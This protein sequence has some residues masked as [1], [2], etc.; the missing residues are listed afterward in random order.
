MRRKCYAFCM[1]VIICL[2]MAGQ[3]ALASGTPQVSASASGASASKGETV[4]VTISLKNNP[5]ISTFGVT[6]NYHPDEFQYKDCKWS[7]ALGGN[8]MKMVSDEEG[9]V[10][11]SL[12]C[13]QSYE[14]EGT[15][16]TI[17]F[18]AKKD[19]A[20]VNMTLQLREM[21][22]ENLSDVE[23][24]KLVKAVQLPKAEGK[25]T[26]TKQ[27][28]T[29]EKEQETKK[30]EAS[31]KAEE[32]KQ[33]V[34]TKE[35]EVSKKVENQVSQTKSASS[36]ETAQKTVR[37]SK[38]VNRTE[39]KTATSASKLDENYKT[40]VAVGVDILFVIAAICGLGAFIF[41]NEQKK[42]R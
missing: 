1:M 32:Q 42:E 28:N 14:A 7:S 18:Q 36:T 22:D 29:K 26:A 6:L 3:P 8:D 15:V 30:K 2:V 23:N 35:A 10:N 21:A 20:A 24:C 5:K 34:V 12:V 17:V 25:E 39:M 16:A 38:S 19:V 31:K 33:E 37:E 27:N 41:W 9:N 13:D 4:K 11:V 40:G